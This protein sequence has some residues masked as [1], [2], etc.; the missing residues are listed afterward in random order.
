MVSHCERQG[1]SY[2][3]HLSFAHFGWFSSTAVV[4]FLWAIQGH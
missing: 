2:A 3:L 1:F 4:G